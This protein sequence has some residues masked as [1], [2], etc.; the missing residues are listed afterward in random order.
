MDGFIIIGNGNA[1]TYKEI[2]P[3]I[4]E[5]KLW[6]GYGNVKAYKTNLKRVENEKTQYIENGV[7]YQKFGNTCWYTNIEHNKR[8]EGIYLSET[9][10][11]EKYPK[12]DNYD[13][14]EVSRVENIPMDYDGIMG[15]PISFLDKYCPSQF[16]LIG[17][18]STDFAEKI[19]IKPM[20]EEF[21]R[22]YRANG[23]TGHYTE[24]MR[25]LCYYENDG[26]PKKVYSR[27]LIKK[28]VSE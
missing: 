20:G 9:Y 26:T 19:G 17:I 7:V 2:F 3:L 28:K 14:I 21:I 25:N 6:L 23:G 22:R 8:K 1:V 4:K 12:Y 13:A 5:N 24:G 15:V 10:S 16:E 27:I 11:D 18:D